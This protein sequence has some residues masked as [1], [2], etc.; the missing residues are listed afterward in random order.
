M[1]RPGHSPLVHI[2]SNPAS[3]LYERLL[4]SAWLELANCI[5]RLH[6]TLSPTQ[7]HGQFSVAHGQNLVSR[8]LARVLRLPPESASTNILLTVDRK[9]DAEIWTRRFGQSVVVTRQSAEADDV[10]CERFGLMDFRFKLNV[11]KGHLVY[12]QTAAS[13]RVGP[14]SFGL[15]RWLSPVIRAVEKPCN[16]PDSVEVSVEVTLPL[17]GLLLAYHGIMDRGRSASE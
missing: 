2:D 9:G 14:C 5:Q 8:T 11:E 4:G 1:A 3:S 16:N 12:R 6:A 10:L 15:P 17:S 13:L 7:I